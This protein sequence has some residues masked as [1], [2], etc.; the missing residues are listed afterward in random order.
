M[1]AAAAA[2]PCEL[3]I[4]RHPIERDEIA[5]QVAKSRAAPGVVVRYGE[6]GGLYEALEGAWLLLTG[7]SNTVFEAALSNVPALC[8]NATDGPLPMP[9]VEEGIAMGATDAAEATEAVRALLE[10]NSAWIDA[11]ARPGALVDHLGPLDG[12]ATGRLVE[13]V[14]EMRMAAGGSTPARDA[15]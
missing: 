13:L 11:I 2:A 4:Q 15:G 1:V 8:I 3:I 5:A 9:F 6:P 12:R 10:S 14:M 7:W